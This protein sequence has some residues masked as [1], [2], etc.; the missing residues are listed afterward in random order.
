MMLQLGR[1]CC[2]LVSCSVGVVTCQLIMNAVFV[3]QKAAQ[4]NIASQLSRTGFVQALIFKQLTRD[5]S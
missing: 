5:E 2:Q 3:W 1:N 4:R